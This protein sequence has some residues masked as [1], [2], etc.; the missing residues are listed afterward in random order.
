MVPTRWRR[1]TPRFGL[2]RSGGERMR[3]VH[4]AAFGLRLPWAEAGSRSIPIGARSFAGFSPPCFVL[5]GAVAL[6]ILAADGGRW[7]SLFGSQLDCRS[8]LA[9]EEQD[10]SR[11]SEGGLLR[12]CDFGSRKRVGGDVG[13]PRLFIPATCP[14][15]SAF[16]V[17]IRVRAFKGLGLSV[18]PSAPIGPSWKLLS[19][20]WA[21][22]DSVG[23]PGVGLL[24]Q[25]PWP[26][27]SRWVSDPHREVATDSG[28][29]G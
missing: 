12:S 26:G 4:R 16:C 13:S 23:A 18:R 24:V 5:G 29:L 14:L 22:L 10:G 21:S 15:D 6:Q 20:R 2:Q 8:A 25:Q 9:W 11:R 19:G 27:W 28:T 17:A 3:G 7:R 1:R